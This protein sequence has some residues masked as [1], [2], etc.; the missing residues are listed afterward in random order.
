MGGRGGD[1]EDDDL[2]ALTGEELDCC[3][4]YALG[5]ACYEDIFTAKGWVDGGHSGN[6]L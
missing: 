5:T 1:V 3:G 4:T 6:V 2:A